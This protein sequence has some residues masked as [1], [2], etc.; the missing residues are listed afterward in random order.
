[1]IKFAVGMTVFVIVGNDKVSFTFL[2]R[3]ALSSMSYD[4]LPGVFLPDAPSAELHEHS[5]QFLRKF[6]S[7]VLKRNGA[8]HDIDPRVFQQVDFINVIK[9]E[10]QVVALLLQSVLNFESS[11]IDFHPY[12]SN[13]KEKEF[14]RALKAKGV[15]SGLTCEYLTVDEAWR[16]NPLGLSMAKIIVGLGYS[17]QRELGIDVS[18]GRCRT[19]VGSDL[20]MTERGGERL[21]TNVMM[22]NT[23]I[24]FC[25]LHINQMTPHPNPEVEAVTEALWSRRNDFA[26]TQF[27]ELEHRRQTKEIA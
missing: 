10:N 18:I 1:M 11:A 2:S 26:T 7:E 20:L 13:A 9:H 5:F 12:F 4:I 23:P 6:W 3:K 15:R 25:V 22:H 24:D 14:L 19:D 21:I 27:K 16:K 17:I 8:Q